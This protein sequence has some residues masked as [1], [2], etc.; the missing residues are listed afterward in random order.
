M[1]TCPHCKIQILKN[2]IFCGFCGQKVKFSKEEKDRQKLERQKMRDEKRVR[3][4]KERQRVIAKNRQRNLEIMRENADII[5]SLEWISSKSL[6]TCIFCLLMDGQTFSLNENFLR[7]KCQSD[8]GCRCS[9]V[10]VLKGLRSR[11]R[12]IGKKWFLELSES[13]KKIILGEEEFL[14]W[15]NGKSLEE[16][17]DL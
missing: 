14:N 13:D 16:I 1:K 12:T 17:A 15:K 6:R 8:E 7:E 3:K 10:A 5:E 11:P 9:T 4:V 2:S